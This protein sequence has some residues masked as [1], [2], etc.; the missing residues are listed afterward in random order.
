MYSL[1]IN[2][3]LLIQN[4]IH[5]HYPHHSHNHFQYHLSRYRHFHSRHHYHY[6]HII[7]IFTTTII[8][9]TIN[10]TI[11]NT[12]ITI[13][14]IRITT[15]LTTITLVTTT[16]F[17]DQINYN[18]RR[19]PTINTITISI[20]QQAHYHHH[21]SLLTAIVES[22]VPLSPFSSK[23]HTIITSRAARKN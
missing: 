11:Y 17:I 13:V 5:N 21:C 18:T 14:I 3:Y 22:P 16:T 7:I 23:N 20:L 12:A 4:L 9:A 6:Q 1:A 19:V 15:E 8:S 2:I 10:T